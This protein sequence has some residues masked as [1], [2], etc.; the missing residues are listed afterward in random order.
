[1]E[2]ND[3]KEPAIIISSSGMCEGGRIRHHLKNNIDDPNNLI[4]F[5]GFCAEHT[6]GAQILSGREEVNIFGEPH[7]VRARV[8]SIDS[9]SGHAD[10][11]E[12]LRYVNNLTGD[13]RKIFV[14]HGEEEQTTAF[15]E[16]LRGVKPNAEV[17]APVLLQKE[18]V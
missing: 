13:I 17:V 9:F 14:C 8:A 12:L 7:K 10:K 3:L 16:T 18:E 6:L 2:L 15:A 4:L 1:M 11:N 5:I